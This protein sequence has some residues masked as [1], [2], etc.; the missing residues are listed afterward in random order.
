[1][2]FLGID[3]GSKRVGVAVSDEGGR[4]A[5]P[6]DIFENGSKLTNKIKEV[7]A[8]EGISKIV[9]GQS[10]DYKMQP[11]EIMREIEKFKTDLGKEIN[12]PIETEIEVLT[13]VQASRQGQIKNLD[14]SA[15]ALILQ[16]YLDRHCE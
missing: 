10:L 3:Y 16:S 1:M 15:A 13:S 2:R 7:C 5:F 9:V 6:Y 11:N 8:G 12:L 4:L 14:A